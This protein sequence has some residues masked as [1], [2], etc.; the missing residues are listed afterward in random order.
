MAEKKSF[1]LYHDF[2]DQMQLLSIEQRGELLTM[3]YEYAVNG[4]VMT[5]AS[6]MTQFAFLGIRGQ[7]DRDYDKYLER[8]QINAQNAKKGGRPKKDSKTE[9]FFEKPKKPDNDN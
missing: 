2:Y 1:I 4:R 5:G 3:I 6:P 7:M 8:C 9:R